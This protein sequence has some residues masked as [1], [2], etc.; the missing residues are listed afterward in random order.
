MIIRLKLSNTTPE[1]INSG[2]MINKM[3]PTVEISWN[4]IWVPFN[5]ASV[6]PRDHTIE[7]PFLN[8]SKNGASY[9]RTKSDSRGMD[10]SLNKLKLLPTLLLRVKII[11]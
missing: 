1:K 4:L 7:L 9:S 11:L 2:E 10:L 6:D 3:P 8:K 5:H